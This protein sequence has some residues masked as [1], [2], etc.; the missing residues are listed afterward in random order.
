MVMSAPVLNAADTRT[1]SAADE[2]DDRTPL[3]QRWGGWY[4]TGRTGTQSHFGNLPLREERGGERLQELQA[5]RMDIMSIKAYVDASHWPT[6]HSDVVALL[7]LEH[8]TGLQNL[9][10]RANY[11]VRTVMSRVHDDATAAMPRSWEEVNPADQKRLQ[12][13]IE[14]LVRMMFFQDAAPYGH[15]IE[16]SSGFAERFAKLGPKDSKGRGLHELDLN[17]HLLRH[18]LSY[19]IYS[20]QFDGLPQYAL[21]YVYSRIV[22][23]LQGRDTTGISARIPADERK[24]IT[25]ILIDTKPALAA[26]LRPATH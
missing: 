22:E 14:P 11:K 16:G 10:T 1:A 13:M 2:T 7:A 20:E 5:Q 15:R 21:D 9:I 19:E 12:S 23:V 8:Q 4:V 24:A 6:D 3:E 25:E 26:L 17:T 18:P